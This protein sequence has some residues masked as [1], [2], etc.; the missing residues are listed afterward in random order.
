MVIFITHNVRMRA[1]MTAILANNMLTPFILAPL[2]RFVEQHEQ[3]D[4]TPDEQVTVPEPDP[5]PDFH[6]IKETV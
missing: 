1:N 6:V 2:Q 5:P 4:G 3:P